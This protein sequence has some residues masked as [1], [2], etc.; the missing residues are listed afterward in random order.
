MLQTFKDKALSAWFLIS[1]LA[2][3][4]LYLMVDR[5][6]R[7]I[8]QLKMDAEKQVLAQKLVTIRNDAMRSDDHYAKAMEDY[9]NIKRRHADLLKRFGLHP[10]DQSGSDNH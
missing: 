9:S 8:G 6:N 5:R 1:A 2:L 10:G 4:V 7:T 3:A